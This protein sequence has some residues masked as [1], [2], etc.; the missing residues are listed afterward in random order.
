MAAIRSKGNKATELRLVSI[1]RAHGIKVGFAGQP[2]E[3]TPAF[4]AVG[5]QD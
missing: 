5:A 2:L 1:L 4:D 3:P